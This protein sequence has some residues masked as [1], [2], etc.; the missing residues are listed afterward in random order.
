MSDNCMRPVPGSPAGISRRDLLEYSIRGG[1][2]LAMSTLPKSILASTHSA[3]PLAGGRPIQTTTPS[4]PV[5]QQQY[6]LVRNPERSFTLKFTDAP[7]RRPGPNEVLVKVHFASLNRRDIMI[8]QQKGTTNQ[9]DNFVPLTDGAGEV[10]EIGAGTTRF[11]VGDR[12][13]AIFHQNWLSGRRSPMSPA[14]LGGDL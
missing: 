12:V 5:M 7:V 14:A 6:Q 13:A 10:V 2:A 4:L 8:V 3:A 1:A 9:L 11:H